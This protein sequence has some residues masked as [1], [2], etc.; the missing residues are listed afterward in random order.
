MN[1]RSCLAA[2]AALAVLARRGPA[3]AAAVAADPVGVWRGTSLCQ[4]RPSPCNDEI[5]VY[6]ITRAKARD[7][8]SVDARK[9]VNGR[10]EEMGILACR[11]AALGASFTCSMPNGVWRFT[12]RGDSLVGDLRLP[13]STRY[14][15][16]R[17]ARSR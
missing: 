3:Q 6:R 16:V 4:V 12:L 17:A 5:V 15:D 14:R 1:L 7:T 8:I 13:D 9:I 11:L 10:E 2:I